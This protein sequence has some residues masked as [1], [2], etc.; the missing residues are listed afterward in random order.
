MDANIET[1]RQ[2]P[3][4]EGEQISISCSKD[5]VLVSKSRDSITCE[6]SKTVEGYK[7]TLPRCVFPGDIVCSSLPGHWNHMIPNIMPV[8]EGWTVELTCETGYQLTGSSTVTCN[9]TESWTWEGS[10]QPKCGEFNKLIKLRFS[11]YISL[12]SGKRFNQRQYSI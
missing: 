11:L 3:I 8:E 10:N 7:N 1:S 5:L 12:L 4:N 2:L 6:T 9:A